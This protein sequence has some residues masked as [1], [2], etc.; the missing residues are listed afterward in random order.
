MIAL[1]I[2][3][4]KKTYKTGF[5]KGEKLEALKG[6]SIQIEEGEIYGFL[7][8]NG[9]GKTTT[10]LSM[11]DLIKRDSGRV[12]FFEKEVQNN[13][14]IFKDIGYVPEE[15]YLYNY[16]KV[17]EFLYFGAK[18]SNFE[19]K[20][21]KEKIENYLKLFNLYEKRESIIKNLSKGQKQRVLLS[22]NF[23]IQPKILILD[24]PFRGLDPIGI[25]SVR[26]E[27]LALSQNGKTI[28]LSSHIISEVEMVCNKVS[29]INNGEI[30]WEGNPRQIQK[31][32]SAFKI[33]FKIKKQAGE[34]IIEK[35]FYNQ[36]DLIVFLKELNSSGGE[37][38]EILKE[39][40]LED[41]FLE[42]IR[43]N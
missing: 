34:N 3:N 38:I 40:S 15:P 42:K 25:K 16:L 33:Y 29:I 4:L 20:N 37:I 23:L 30:I 32:E 24:E 28:F 11:L 6:I 8:P 41:Y 18:L 27:I 22:L 35:K 12:F 19:E 43:E 10:I 39:K 21:L 17:E 5:F 13:S 14:E 31:K 2:E 9:A 26:D 1:R 7:G 36:D